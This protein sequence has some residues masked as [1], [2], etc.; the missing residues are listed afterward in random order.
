[1]DVATAERLRRDGAVDGTLELGSSPRYSAEQPGDEV[2]RLRTA[3]GGAVAVQRLREQGLSA[4]QVA[5]AFDAPTIAVRDTDGATVSAQARTLV[6]A[7]LLMLYMSVLVYGAAVSSAIVQEKASRVTEVMMARVT[8]LAHMAGKLGGVGLA[9]LAQFAIWIGVAL[10]ILAANSLLGGASGIELA[11]VPVTTFLAFGAFFVLGFTLYGALYAGLSAPASRIEDATAAGA[12]PG[13][14]IVASFLAATVALGDP[15]SSAARVLSL[16]PPLSPMTM[17][18]R[19]A[20]GSPPLWEVVLSVALL[21]ATI[22]LVLVLSAKVY[23]A[24]LLMYGTR[25]GLI[26]T[27]R[28]MRST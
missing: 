14:L 16:I 18:T 28:L 22:T 1:A 20:L 21:L 6:Y 2:A 9:G 11:D 7:L 8:P 10:A 27:L 12:V 25:P 23:R 26:G 3:V 24:A 17:F 19:V 13:I 4:R 15:E 5:S